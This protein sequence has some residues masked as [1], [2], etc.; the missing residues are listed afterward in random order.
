[1]KK[2]INLNS[3]F[4]ILLSSLVVILSSCG[5]SREDANLDGLTD[6]G[7]RGRK[8]YLGWGAAAAGDPQMMHNEVRYDVQHTSD[9]FTK[10]LGGSYIGT[11]IFGAEARGQKIIQKWTDF[12]TSMTK[13]DMYI[14]YSSGHGVRS[15]LAIGLSWREMTRHL[16]ELPSK[17]TIIF[18]MA[19][20]S[21]NF[22]DAMNAQKSSWQ[23]RTAEGRTLFLMSSSRSSETSSTGP[24]VDKTLPGPNGSAGSAYGHALWKALAG[25]ADGSIDGI[26]DGYL[27]LEEI[28]AYTIK[29]T[30]ELGGHTPQITGSFNPGLIM[31]RVPTAK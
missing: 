11:T 21:G 25:G 3:Q 9:V 13:D 2:E 27:T 14:Q 1:M 24:G 23:N 17:E 22:V 28:S 29:R 7:F 5:G 15:G 31:S 6:E 4:L 16:L 12:K 26:K 18:T 20:Y 8:Y 30:K 19:C 10:D